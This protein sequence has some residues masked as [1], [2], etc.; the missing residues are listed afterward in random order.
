MNCP[1]P[2][3]LLVQSSS[4]S[5]PA[6][7]SPLPPIR[8]SHFLE[9]LAPDALGNSRDWGDISQDNQ[10]HVIQ[11]II[12]NAQDRELSLDETAFA[13]AVAR[14][15]SGFNPDAASRISTA[16]GLGQF[17][18]ATG[19]AYGITARF[20]LSQ[21]IEA[22]LQHLKDLGRTLERRRPFADRETKLAHTYWLY[23]DGPSLTSGGLEIAIQSVIPWYHQF[24]NWLTSCT[25][26]PPESGG[27]GQ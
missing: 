22:L 11:A 17:I 16:S 1:V 6:R 19:H 13:L 20:S 3:S 15:E 4:T 27:K 5:S 18:D 7:S 2:P 9:R 23:H 25:Q 14:L 8:R 21:G 10:R 26:L 12:A 24:R